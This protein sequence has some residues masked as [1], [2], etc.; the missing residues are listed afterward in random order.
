MCG[1]GGQLR[2]WDEERRSVYVDNWSEWDVDLSC[3][4]SSFVVS[5]TSLFADLPWGGYHDHV[6]SNGKV[7]HSSVCVHSNGST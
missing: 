3:L 5:Y 4:M 2:P 6:Y 1:G 7:L